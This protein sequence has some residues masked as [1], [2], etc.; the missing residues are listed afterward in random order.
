MQKT[1]WRLTLVS[2]FVFSLIIAAAVFDGQPAQAA[3]ADG[4]LVLSQGTVYLVSGQQQRRPFRSPEVF[5]S[6]GYQFSEVRLATADDLALPVGPVMVF[7]DGSLVKEPNNSLVYLVSNGKKRGFTSADVF[8][9]LGYSFANVVTANN[10]T[11][12]DLPSDAVIDS[13][14][15]QHPAGTII[16][17]DGTLYRVA[18]GGL[19]AFDSPDTYFSYGH[20]FGE[21]V[22]AAPADTSLPVVSVVAPRVISPSSTSSSPASPAP[23]DLSNKKTSLSGGGSSIAVQTPNG[24]EVWMRNEP[25]IIQWTDSNS[26]NQNYN[27]YLTNQNGSE[28]VALLTAGPTH[29]GGNVWQAAWEVGQ[30]SSGRALAGA[31][32]K[33][34]VQARYLPQNTLGD[35]DESDGTFEIRDADAPSSL[36]PDFILTGGEISPKLPNATNAIEINKEAIATF[37]VK[38][39]GA[40]SA[41]MPGFAVS[42]IA[43]LSPATSSADFGNTCQTLSQLGANQT[44][45]YALKLIYNQLSSGA[46]Y[47]SVKLEVNPSKAIAESDYSN[48][49]AVL[50]FDVRPANSVPTLTAILPTSGPAG[51]LATLT[52]TDLIL[53]GQ[54]TTVKFGTTPAQFS[55]G[56]AVS[57]ASIVV[58]NLPPGTYPVSVQVG[59]YLTN[60][61]NFT[62]T[63]AGSATPIL[64][65]LSPNG[66]EKWIKGSIYS[67]KWSAT[68]LGNVNLILYK[69]NNCSYSSVINGQVCGYVYPLAPT[70]PTAIAV[71]VPNTGSF[72]WTLPSSLPDGDDYRVAVQNPNYL[73]FI[74][75]SDAPFSI[76]STAQTGSLSVT[77]SVVA[78]NSGETVVLKY[79]THSNAIAKK[80]YWYCPAG[81]KISWGAIE[82]ICNTWQA[83]DN[84]STQITVMMI[85]TVSQAQNTVPNFYEYLPDNPGYAYGV[86][87]QVTVN[88][89]T[90]VQPS[91]TV[92]SP[93]GGE[94]MAVGSSFIIRWN[95]IGSIPVVDITTTNIPGRYIASSISNNGSFNWTIPSD[96]PPGQY[97][98]RITPPTGDANR[99]SDESDAPF[100]IVA[101]TTQP[102]LTVLSPAGGEQWLVGSPQ[103]IQ[104]SRSGDFSG[105]NNYYFVY[106]K[107]IKDQLLGAT[108]Y[109]GGYIPVLFRVQNL[110]YPSFT[111]TVPNTSFPGNFYLEFDYADA[112]GKPIASYTTNG[113]VAVTSS[114][115]KPSLTVLSPNG[116]ESIDLR[117]QYTIRWSTQNLSPASLLGIEIRNYSDRT[118]A[119]NNDSS[120]Y[121]SIVVKD[122]IRADV[123]QFALVFG[124]NPTI[125]S[126]VNSGIKFDN[127]KISIFTW[128]P[129]FGTY[130]LS[131]APFSIATQANLAQKVVF[132]LEGSDTP[133]TS[134]IACGTRVTFKITNYTP[135]QIWLT[136]LKDGVLT[137][138]GL[139]PVPSTYTLKCLQDEG[140]F[141]NNVY[142]LTQTNQKGTIIDGLAMQVIPAQRYDP[143][144]T[145]V[146]SDTPLTSSTCDTPLTFK[147]TNYPYPQVWLTKTSGDAL[148]GGAILY[149]APYSVPSTFTP[150]CN[151]DEGQTTNTAYAYVNGRKG[152]VLGSVTYRLLPSQ[153][154]APIFTLKNSTTPATSFPCGSALRFSVTNY[155]QPQVWLRQ[156]KNYAYQPGYNGPYNVPVEFTVACN[157]DEGTYINEV[158]YLLP[159]NQRGTYFGSITAT[160]TPKVLGVST[161]SANNSP[162]MVSIVGPNALPVGLPQTFHGY[163]VDVDGNIITY[164]IDWGDGSAPVIISLGS[165]YPYIAAHAWQNP[166]KYLMSVVALDSLGGSSRATY[167]ITAK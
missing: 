70:P 56:T 127:V 36:K 27:I 74:D 96:F 113:T 140:L 144:F 149:D 108:S 157:Q 68:N 114:E 162:T 8:K 95:S 45:V 90:P 80:L 89:T 119:L 26:A 46:V 43:G 143:I 73:P 16:N 165:G 32:Y 1:F 81:I 29:T 98:L 151:Q 111:V 19:E 49:W 135:A 31:G 61:V 5:F 21:E 156:F 121:T 130:D 117:S 10:E 97:R 116:G 163:A 22:P 160:V 83:L 47:G 134:P 39:Q 17:K 87:S 6:C 78:V 91:I 65:V 42:H 13:V 133:L 14:A 75:Q 67:I 30:Q 139:Y 105:S 110:G 28:A 107:T 124:D 93:N 51:T 132:T 79:T 112:N 62:I 136:Q 145:Q 18:P 57:I 92:L 40:A 35:F 131:D 15:I 33:I 86:S 102:S 60:S 66:G 44:C 154:Q 3:P 100:S 153:P 34:K 85:S 72:S 59:S 2:A 148:S 20:K 25:K 120:R 58:P 23:A 88:P 101:A 166:G 38:N 158:Y 52:G 94:T 104:W 128:V 142:N 125:A 50:N 155:T 9:G 106:L 7:C 82:N 115:A 159:N 77:P 141:V 138:D 64:T 103:T 109:S 24:G 41:Q 55:L 69:G 152:I 122:S 84:G 4:D 137:F 123:G 76:V 118:A 164:I 11:F 146:G 150:H 99:P 167:E 147:V 63:S 48:N 161:D 126:M 12:A 53:L 129:F 71:N 54:S 37:T